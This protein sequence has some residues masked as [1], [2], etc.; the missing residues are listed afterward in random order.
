MPGVVG[1]WHAEAPG[2]WIRLSGRGDG[3]RHADMFDGGQAH[4]VAVQGDGRI[5]AVRR[6]S[7]PQFRPRQ[8]SKIILRQS[9]SGIGRWGRFC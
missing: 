8:R 4:T 2:R 3:K 9:K 1:M 5:I 6:G 7:P